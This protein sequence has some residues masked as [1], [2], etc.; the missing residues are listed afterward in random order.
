MSSLCVPSVYTSGM[1]KPASPAPDSN[2]RPLPYHD[3][4][5]YEATVAW[6]EAQTQ[7]LS[8]A[9]KIGPHQ[10]ELAVAALSGGECNHVPARFPRRKPFEPSRSRR[11]SVH[12]TV[13]WS[14]A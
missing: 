10:V 14:T 8:D 9:A 5:A 2:R 13:H 7:I 1:G 12:G 11:V 4:A 3:G 6:A